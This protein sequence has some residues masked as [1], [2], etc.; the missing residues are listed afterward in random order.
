MAHFARVNSEGIVINVIVVG[1]QDMLDENGDE[2]EA[3]GIAFLDGL[4]PDD[5]DT[6]IQTSYNTHGNQHRNG[7]TPLRKNYASIGY[8]WDSE[9][10]AFIPPKPFPSWTLNEEKYV[11]EAPVQPV[12]LGHVWDEENQQWVKPPKPFESWVWKEEERTDPIVHTVAGW[13]APVDPPEG[14]TPFVTH[15]WDEEEQTWDE[16]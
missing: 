5:T 4:F 7:G 2:S 11:W 1:N 14:S 6:W 8:T 13:A 12:P 10:D 16:V 15:M 3:A 9:K